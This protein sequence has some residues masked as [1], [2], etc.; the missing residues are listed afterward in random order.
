MST[1][2]CKRQR[3]VCFHVE[4]P[5][6]FMGCDQVFLHA[7]HLWLVQTYPIKCVEFLNVF[8]KVNG[9]SKNKQTLVYWLL[10]SDIKNLVYKEEFS[11]Y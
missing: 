8:L 1:E 3:S 2:L 4:I 9:W 11:M 7:F 10:L 5:L 6:K